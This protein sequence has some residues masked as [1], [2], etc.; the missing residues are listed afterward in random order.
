M[1][2]YCDDIHGTVAE[3]RGRGVRFDMDVADHGYGFV[4][5]FTMPGGVKVQL[6]EPKYKKRGAKAKA[7]ARPKAKPKT[8]ARPKRRKRR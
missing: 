7:V 1:S 2:F 8:K 3:L 5:Y 6:Y 4:T